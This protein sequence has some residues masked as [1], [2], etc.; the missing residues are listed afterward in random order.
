MRG[1]FDEGELEPV[2][3]RRDTEL[4]LGSG[5]LLAIF[6]GLVLLCG[7]CFGLGYAMGHRGAEST[8]ASTSGANAQQ[9]LAASSASKPSA[10]AQQAS[11][12]VADSGTTIDTSQP[13][14]LPIGT[15]PVAASQTAPAYSNSSQPAGGG[16]SQ[17][18]PALT[19]GTAVA[20]A[21]QS[22][23]NGAVH[24]ALGSSGSFMVQIAAVSN[25]EDADVL[26]TAL[27]RRGYAVTEQHE[28]IDNLI[29]VRIGPFATAA[30]ANNW[31]TRL[32]NDGYNAIVQ[33]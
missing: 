27:R 9:P 11:T 19:P 6:F 15:V 12:P 10:A 16:Q 17:V 8:V 3:A 2:N 32:L 5:T 1:V 22:A 25:Q 28:P 23:P 24:P 26:A 29:H 30:E 7:I 20:P 33:Q 13:Q 4:T 18:H 21:L 31:K 14:A